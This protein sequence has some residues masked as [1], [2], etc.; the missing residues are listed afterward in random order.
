MKVEHLTFNSGNAVVRDTS[1]ISLVVRQ[2]LSA[3]QLSYE[4]RMLT[5]P[6][7]LPLK[8]KIS[9]TDEGAAF[10]IMKGNHLAIFNLCCFEESQSVMVLEVLRRVTDDVS[11]YGYPGKVIEPVTPQWLYSVIID[12]TNMTPIDWETAGEVELYI[13]DQLFTA[14]NNRN[15]TFTK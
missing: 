1:E 9:A 3:I 8:L 7:L 10:D 14:Y 11:K 6:A 13:Y 4:S 2:K 12:P 5:V 15:K